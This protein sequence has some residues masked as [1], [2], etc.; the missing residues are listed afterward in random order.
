MR[1]KYTSS[2]FFTSNHP[3]LLK[4]MKSQSTNLMEL[5]ARPRL[6]LSGLLFALFDGYQFHQHCYCLLVEILFSNFFRLWKISSSCYHSWA[7]FLFDVL[8]AG[9]HLCLC[10]WYYVCQRRAVIFLNISFNISLH[11]LY[12]AKYLG[13]CS[14]IIFQTIHA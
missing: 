4:Y 14:D 2:H 3:F 6:K 5:N 8:Y 13:C 7:G 12:Q 11:C 9:W 10:F 1:V